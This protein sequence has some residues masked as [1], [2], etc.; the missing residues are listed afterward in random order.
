MVVMAKDKV[1]YEGPTGVMEEE[2]YSYSSTYTC[3]DVEKG[4][5][6]VVHKTKCKDGLKVYVRNV[7]DFGGMDQEEVLEFAS[8]AAII[9]A[10]G[11]EF[12]SRTALKALEELEGRTLVAKDYFK[13]ERKNKTF[14]EKVQDLVS[15]GI[16]RED[17][18]L[19]LK[20]PVAFY[21]KMQAAMKALGK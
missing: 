12:R 16:E 19:M 18:E 15:S 21:Q 2:G 11:P 8:K 20:D 7:M 14:E 6:E 10:R 9:A 5:V 1:K 3:T 17:A 4:L 13:R